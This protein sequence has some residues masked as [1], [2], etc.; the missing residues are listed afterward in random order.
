M[1]LRLGRIAIMTVAVGGCAGSRS[2][3]RPAD[4]RPAPAVVRS[5]L[6]GIAD[7]ITAVSHRYPELSRWHLREA[8]G[9]G[10][11]YEFRCKTVRHQTCM[12]IRRFGG[13]GC[14]I[15]VWATRRLLDRNKMLTRVTTPGEQRSKTWIFEPIPNL[16][17]T[18]QARIETGSRTSDGFMAEMIRITR[19]HLDIVKKEGADPSS[20]ARTVSA[21]SVPPQ[22]RD[23]GSRSSSFT[24]ER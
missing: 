7:D 5:L 10:L 13:H 6:Q 9:M 4:A 21:V 14:L 16:E 18:I 24:R 8:H 15:S 20:A 12:P 19:K 22:T 2:T 17:L 11:R 23:S 3:W 1:R